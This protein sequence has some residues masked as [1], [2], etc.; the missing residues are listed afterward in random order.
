MT[1]DYITIGEIKIPIGSQ[2]K[3][4]LTKRISALD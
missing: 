4:A 1:P 2:F 3:S